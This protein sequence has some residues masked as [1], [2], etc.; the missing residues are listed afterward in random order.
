MHIVFKFRYIHN[1]GLLS[2]LFKRI[3]TSS[4]LSLN[5]YNDG[6]MFYIESSG[7][8]KELE[9][10]AELISSI[11]PKS[12]F[13][14]D[15]TLEEIETLSPTKTLDVNEEYFEI[16]YCIECQNK[17]LQ[18][19]NPFEE[20]EVCTVNKK[21][22]TIHEIAPIP[23]DKESSTEVYFNELAE[24]LIEN[25]RLE[26]LTYNGKRCFSLLSSQENKDSSLLVCDPS[27]I[28]TLFSLT[29]GELDLL[30]MIEKPAVRLKPKKLFSLENELQRPFYPVFFAD[31]K[32][33][34]ALTS[35]LSKKGVSL[36][37]CDKAPSLRTATALG[38]NI[39]VQIGRDMLP[40]KHSFSS[41]VKLACN[42]DGY[43]ASVDDNGLILSDI[44]LP[45]DQM[46]VEFISSD[47]EIKKGNSVVFAPAHGALRSVILEHDLDEKSLCSIYLS[48]E[49]T[50]HICSY[51]PKIGYTSMVNFTDD[52]LQT[53]KDMIEAITRM[54]EAGEKLIANFKKA[55]PKL[56]EKL[57]DIS[58]ISEGKT[59]SFSKLW[60]MAAY[61][62][63]LTTTEDYKKASEYL[64]SAALEFQG[65]SGPR[66]D[67][68]VIK[69]KDSYQL[70]P[71]LAI[72]SAISFKLAG[73]DEYLLSFGFIDSLADFIAEQ[74]E[75]A[76]GNIGIDGV[77]L[78][79][80]L[81]ENHQLIM[82]TYNGITPNYKMYRNNRLSIDGANIAAGAVT[83]G[84]E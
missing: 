11:V 38:E 54:D 75:F 64:E 73:V 39:I 71:R 29:Q 30:M 19:L 6:E 34:L 1:N 27:N 40:W 69:A 79:G 63:D 59:S 47:E 66:I 46:G 8:Q 36:I 31:D 14:Y 49:H 56:Y 67:Y 10:L 72:R 74:A 80:S 32:V 53:P 83:L 45:S 16:P 81:F 12:L 62:L 50:S 23:F 48:K 18:T 25:K 21:Y 9:S 2:R 22:F 44:T 5:A 77:V 24:Y 65:K 68:K 20:C 7:T 37:Y 70:D 61:F 78:S 17:I 43:S 35:A 42:F 82:R 57:L 28:S 4:P 3:T 60:A 58:P 55:Y 51:S 84:N 33:T 26:L 76:D 41:K 15:S 52:Y 13:L